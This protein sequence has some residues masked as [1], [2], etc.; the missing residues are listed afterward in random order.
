MPDAV[1]C[2]LVVFDSTHQ[3]LRGE[4]ILKRS[5]VP[6]EVTNTPPHIK[7]DCGISLRVRPVDLERAEDALKAAEVIYS[8]VEPHY[9]RWLY[10]PE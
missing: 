3:A 10:K 9:C 6:H 2:Y 5:C 4:E 7:A 8:R 1:N